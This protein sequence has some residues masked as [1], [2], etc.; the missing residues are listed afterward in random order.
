[1]EVKIIAAQYPPGHPQRQAALRSAKF[2]TPD[3]I[4]TICRQELPW[5][6]N[7]VRKHWGDSAQEHAGAA[8]FFAARSY[9]VGNVP[10]SAWRAISMRNYIR[11][12]TSVPHRITSELSPSIAEKKTPTVA[13]WENA[14]RSL[15]SLSQKLE[16]KKRWAFLLV[17]LGQL[18]VKTTAQILNLPRSSIRR[19]IYDLRQSIPHD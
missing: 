15:L 17:T 9:R 12:H 4:E 16:Q 2:F 1:M 3:Q 13:D 5:A 14:I 19:I 8:L 6:N 11:Q 10:W 18:S 7:F